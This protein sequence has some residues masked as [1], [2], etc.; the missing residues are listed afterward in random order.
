MISAYFDGIFK[1]LSYGGK[2]KEGSS[3]L[4]ILYHLNTAKLYASIMLI[5]LL[6][7]KTGKTTY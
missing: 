2:L 6:Y 5:L 1:I 3:I 4:S 7:G